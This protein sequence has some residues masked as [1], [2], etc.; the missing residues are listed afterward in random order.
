MQIALYPT[1]EG[2]FV[3]IP[4]PQAV[5]DFGLSFVLMKDVPF[6]VPYKV[7]H[8]SEEALTLAG[9]PIAFDSG[10]GA[11]FG[12]GSDNDVSAVALVDGRVL[13]KCNNKKAKKE[14]IFDAGW[15]L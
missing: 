3:L 9:Q 14:K 4:S 11:D 10:V 6:G 7:I 13:V 15:K 12:V 1:D 2:V 5:S 8:E